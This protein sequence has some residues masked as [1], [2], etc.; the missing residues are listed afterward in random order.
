VRR[1]AAHGVA[2][3]TTAVVVTTIVAACGDNVGPGACFEPNVTAY[4]FHIQGFDTTVVFRWPASYMPVRV[5][6]EPVGQLPANVTT[7]MELWRSAFR[8]GE[9]RYTITADSTRADIIVRNPAF[10]PAVAARA[11]RGALV[12]PAD[13][14]GACGGV[15]TDTLTSDG[16]AL[17]APMRAFV[18][19]SSADTAAVT[20]CYHFTVAHELGHALG[21]G[22]HSGDTN[23][24]MHSLPR[25]LALSARDRYTIQLLYHTTP[26]VG[27]PPR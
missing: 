16:A 9:L 20:A 18:W 4:P 7:G 27:P 5:Y 19:P 12:W 26:T 21:L 25:R 2:A 23:D 6:A 13:S 17:T 1:R 3:L 22:S 11:A 14:V 10:P 8:C 24:L 15:T